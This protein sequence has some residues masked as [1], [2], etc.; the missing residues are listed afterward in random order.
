MPKFCCG[1]SFAQRGPGPDTGPSFGDCECGNPVNIA[2]GNATVFRP[3]PFGMSKV[4]PIDPNLQYR[5]TDP[6]IGLFGRGMSFS[7]D[8]FAQSLSAEAVRVIDPGG[9][10]YTLSRE[11]DGVFRSR[12]GRSKSIGMEVTPTN[13]GRSLRLP[14]G[15]RYDFDPAGRLL[16]IQ[17]LAG[18]RT[19]FTLNAQGFPT[20]LTDSTGKVYAFQL[21]GAAPTIRISRITDP[22]GRF[23]EFTY[24]SNLRLQTH[25]DQGGGVTTLEYDTNHRIIKKTD[26]RLAVTEYQYDSRGRVV[27]EK[28]P[29]G[30]QNSF[31]YIGGGDLQ[32]N[33]ARYTDANGN[34]TTYYFT[35][36]RD[37]AWVRDALGRVTKFERDPATNQIKR[38]IDPAGRVTEYTY[39]TRGDRIRTV[40][41]AGKQTLVEYDLRFRKP[42]RIENA[43]G[44]V[45][46]IAY[47]PEGNVA[48]VT[49]AE[50]ETTR[51]TYT[52]AGQIETLT[53][54]L[55]RVTRFTYDAQG[56]LVGKINHAGETVTRSYDA[57][58][59]LVALTD[60]LNRTTGFTYDS[61]D[62]MT[63]IRDAMQG[64]TG[65]AFD[66]N[67]NL[68]QVTDQNNHPVERYTYD[69]RNRVKVKTD[70][71]NKSVTYD[72]DL[73][74]N[75]IRTTD[76]KAQVTEYTY[77]KLN[78][79]TQVRDHDN[80]ITDYVYDLAGNVS[81]ISDTQSGDILMSYDALNRLTE[82]ISAQGTVSYSYDAIGRRTSR[83]LSGG[84]VTTYAYDKA[85]RLKSV[86]LRGRT[87]GYAYDA[88][89]RLAEKVLPNGIRAAY[90]YDDGDRIVGI[91]YSKPD[92]S[93]LET[94]SYAYDRGGQRTQRSIGTASLQEAPAAATYDETNRVTS[95]NVEGEAFSLAYDDNGNLVSRSGPTTGV[96]IYTWNARNQLIAISGP[97]VSASF[98][99]DAMGR[100]IEKTVNGVSTGFI[101]DGDQAV[102]ELKGSA[103][104]VAYH[105][106]LQID[107]VLARYSS[108]G[109]RTLL[110]DALGSV[111]AQAKADHSMET[112]YAY[113]PYG[114]TTTLGVDDGNPLQF[115]GREN[116]GTGLY[117]YR[118]RY[119][120]PVLK[121]FISDDP[122]GIAGGTN[123]YAYVGGNPVSRIDPSG[124]APDCFNV[125]DCYAQAKA[126]Y[127]DCKDTVNP[128]LT[129]LIQIGRCLLIRNPILRRACMVSSTASCAAAQFVCINQLITQQ[130]A[131]DQRMSI[132]GYQFGENYYLGPDCVCY[133]EPRF[134][135]DL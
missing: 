18:N 28:L 68:T 74:G 115:T 17:D 71:K 135:K 111:I 23:V 99:Y 43:L 72:Y 88:V 126:N 12:S 9:V 54:A 70:A 65:F 55:N 49:N 127:Y 20:S 39:N 84:D 13:F 62:R 67:D 45:N 106:G 109:D 61:R 48:S 2:S 16:G 77:D 133:S 37:I 44:N 101:Y 89:G 105:A 35:S 125:G 92:N 76:R 79:T 52:A 4:M 58:N 15:M 59:R 3:R 1:A 93:V 91:V 69:L 56:N 97:S 103:V 7:Y 118:A 107:E 80:R 95:I 119:Y 40:D 110:T 122:I 120:D 14:S 47:D 123:L 129:C 94:A 130:N 29:E 86:T 96:T 25:R 73:A 19:S 131:C 90:S 46:T 8:W 113:S 112:F 75:R 36:M 5:S 32:G 30:G 34:T 87:A 57:A 134:A 102:A 10:S 22:A 121:R 41:A 124:L 114:R 78:R 82:V 38:V 27:L 6:R 81:R 100:R 21:V 33:E 128:D 66:A 60:S 98:R 24:D 83:T 63:E 42:I 85:N 116:D 53:D 108:A 11:A 51:F 104:D 26:P 132:D 31:A 117:Y 50:N 64:V